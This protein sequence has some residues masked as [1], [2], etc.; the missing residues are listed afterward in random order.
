MLNHLQGRAGWGIN[1]YPTTFQ[2]IS[3]LLD[4]P[5]PCCPTYIAGRYRERKQF[6]WDWHA[7]NLLLVTTPGLL[8]WIWLD[9]VEKRMIRDQRLRQEIEEATGVS[10]RG[11]LV[12]TKEL[13]NEARDMLRT[14]NAS[15]LRAQD[16]A[17]AVTTPGN[18]LET[19]VR[20]PIFTTRD[21]PLAHVPLP[22][23][24]R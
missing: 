4:V 3:N 12:P 23:P 9:S 19:Q 21:F 1:L 20:R 6:G 22:P 24:E 2:L 14:K 13:Q 7:W 10:S 5:F 17:R 8:L 16:N 18:G 15:A 11:Y